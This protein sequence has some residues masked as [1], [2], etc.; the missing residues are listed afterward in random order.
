MY[1]LP[2]KLG[3]LVQQYH[4]FKVPPFVGSTNLQRVLSSI[5]Y[6]IFSVLLEEWPIIPTSL[7]VHMG[8]CTS[9][10]TIKPFITKIDLFIGYIFFTLQKN[11]FNNE[12]IYNIKSMRFKRNFMQS[13]LPL[14]NFS[15]I[16]VTTACP[17][18]AFHYNDQYLLSQ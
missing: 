14:I 16:L 4:S 7:E 3:L 12:F 18:S 17:Q 15:N 5:L 13:G 2:M 6:S 11:F 9:Y 10:W 1:N 8:M